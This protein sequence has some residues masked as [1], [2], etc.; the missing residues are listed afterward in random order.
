MLNLTIL[1]LYLAS[2][3]SISPLYATSHAQITLSTY[4]QKSI[5]SHFLSPIFYSS[6]NSQRFAFTTNVVA[7]ILST[8]LIFQQN[9]ELKCNG[10]YGNDT[11]ITNSSPELYRLTITRDSFPLDSIEKRTQFLENCLNILI[12]DCTFLNC[13]TTLKGGAIDI[14]SSNSNVTIIQSTFDSCQTKAS[15]D[16][17]GAGIYAQCACISIKQSIFR[18]C[19]GIEPT[20]KGTAAYIIADDSIKIIDSIALNCS[21]ENQP[22]DFAQLWLSSPAMTTSQVNASLGNSNHC[23]GIHY[24]S[25]STNFTSQFITL[26]K[27]QGRSLMEIQQIR[28]DSLTLSYYSLISNVIIAPEESLYLIAIDLFS[29]LKATNQRIINFNQ[30]QVL[31]NNLSANQNVVGLQ[32]QIEEP[33]LYVSDLDS[34]IDPKQFCNI[35][36]PVYLNSSNQLA[37]SIKFAQI[38]DVTE[39]QLFT[40]SYEFTNTKTFSD[41]EIFSES[42]TLKSIIFSN[43]MNFSNSIS[44][45]SSLLFTKS[46]PFTPSSLFKDNKFSKTSLALFW[47]LIGISCVIVILLIV[48]IVLCC[49]KKRKKDE[50]E[51]EDEHE[52][53]ETDGSPYVFSNNENIDELDKENDPFGDNYDNIVKDDPFLKAFSK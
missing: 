18:N 7:H 39:S 29:P 5:F 21:C 30:F 9:D 10:N 53:T 50:P 43:S 44:F 41:S 14:E 33:L 28:M 15:Q 26:Y 3:S 42:E 16:S 36:E 8:P 24:D 13:E 32:N 23:S 22:N 11:N 46:Q 19:N 35:M 38:N 2:Q 45:T 4:L 34:D 6:S 31:D 20:T 52:M 1:S 17:M 27:N 25:F 37:D 47:T 51:V 40:E 48:I 12:L 49:C